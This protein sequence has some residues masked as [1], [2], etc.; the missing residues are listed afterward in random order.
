MKQVNRATPTALVGAT[1][2]LQVVLWSGKDAM[3]NKRPMAA[4]SAHLFWNGTDTAML[5]RGSL[6]LSRHSQN[7]TASRTF[8]CQLKPSLGGQNDLQLSALQKS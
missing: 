8:A 5:T 1:A 3:I 2:D 4:S 6:R 7:G